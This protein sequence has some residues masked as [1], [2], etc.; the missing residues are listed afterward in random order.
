MPHLLDG[1]KPSYRRMIWTALEHPDKLVKVATLAGVC[2]GKYSPHSA[3]S[4]PAVVSEMVHARIFDGQGSHGSSSIYKPWNNEAAAPRYI[5]AKLSKAYRSMISP[6]IPLVEYKES[7]L[8]SIYKEPLYIPSPVPLAMCFNARGIGVGIR[9]L[10]PN[11]S[12]KSMLEAYLKDDYKLL[13]ANGDLEI[14]YKDSELKSIW[15]KGYGKVT[16][17]FSLDTTAKLEGNLGVALK[18]DPR[19]VQLVKLGKLDTKTYK[20]PNKEDDLGWIDKGLVTMV[21]QSTRG[22]G[23]VIYFGIP[24]KSKSKEKVTR[25]ELIEEL[26]KIRVTSAKYNLA[27]TDGSITKV[28]PLKDWIDSTYKNFTGLVDSY[29]KS[30]LKKLSIKK[31]VALN[32]EAIVDE[33]RTTPTISKDDIAKNLGLDLIVVEEALKKSI[34]VLM[35]VNKTKELKSIREEIK[36]TKLLKPSNF[37]E[38]IINR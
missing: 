26:S 2:G 35:K 28:R 3:D 15:E 19:F 6:L 31:L 32:S 30:K 38:D 24:K 8:N 10:T 22:G 21:D 7:E 12:I 29:K 27:V 36:S 20:S 11:F 17:Q 37:Y 9:A 1:L 13:K 34:S 25:K 33:I 14:D 5:E 16:Y 23:K 18:G 4:L